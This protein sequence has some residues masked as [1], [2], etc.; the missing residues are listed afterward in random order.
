[1]KTKV[2]MTRIVVDPRDAT[3][4]R[5]I[6]VEEAIRLYKSGKIAFDVT[7]ESYAVRA[8]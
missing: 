8:I 2:R 6:P 4:D 7:N 1:M 5:F 3:K